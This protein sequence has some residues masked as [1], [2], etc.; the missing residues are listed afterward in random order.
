ME[1]LF[2]ALV[3]GA[4]GDVGVAWMDARATETAQ[5]NRPLWNT[6]YRSS[7][8]GGATWSAETQLSGLVRGYG[9][10][11]RGAP[12]ELPQRRGR[13]L[14]PQGYEKI[15]E[16][17][18]CAR[19]TVAEALKALEDAGIISWVEDQTGARAMQR[20]LGGQRDKC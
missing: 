13:R 12:V 11:A 2:P 16:A 17:A 10:G 4:A 18:G 9:G 14:L 20:S 8:N 6:Y 1:H 19:S 3:A 5:P 15:A 7:T